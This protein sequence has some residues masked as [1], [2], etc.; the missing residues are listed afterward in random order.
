MMQQGWFRGNLFHARFSPTKHKFS[1]K[2]NMFLIKIPMNNKISKIGFFTKINFFKY[3]YNSLKLNLKQEIISK[4][5][6]LNIDNHKDYDVYLMTR[7][8]QFGFQFNPISFYFIYQNNQ[9]LSIL[10]EVSNTPWNE[11]I[12][13]P[14][15]ISNK[16]L[17]NVSGSH[18]NRGLDNDLANNLA[19]SF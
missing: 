1:Y 8:A 12:L 4:A 18:N 5:P 6:N 19:K 7:P 14:L 16:N 13:Y 10:L 17:S 11:K 15:D 9:L 3:G 2:D